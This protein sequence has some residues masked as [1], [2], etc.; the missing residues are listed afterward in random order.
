MLS[1]ISQTEPYNL[2]HMWDIKLKAAEERT[3]TTETQS[4]AAVRWLPEGRA[5]G[6]ETVTGPK[7]MG[8]EDAV[9]GWGHTVQYT[10]HVWQ[11][12][13]RETYIVSLTNVTPLTLIFQKHFEMQRIR[14]QCLSE[15]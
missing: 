11:K 6:V 15:Q 2:T 9:T 5:E 7:Y 8:T 1:G 3:R 14:M 12:C 13:T 4:Q 10:G